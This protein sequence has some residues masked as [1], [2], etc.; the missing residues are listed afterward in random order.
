MKMI[1]ATGNNPANNQ[2]RA[3]RAFTLIELILVMALLVVVVSMVTPVFARFFNGRKA[4]S[5]VKQLVSLMQ[6]GRSRA[7]SE[8]AP[9]MLWVNAANGTYGLKEQTGYSDNDTNA[10]DFT[11]A[12]G[13]KLD[14]DRTV[15]T[16]L[17]ANSQ[18]GRILSGQITQ[19][20]NQLPAIYFMP[21]G[22][23]NSASS[24]RGISVQDGAGAPVW[25]V[26]SSNQMN[27]AVQTQ[28]EHLAA[29]RR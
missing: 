20:K 9:M 2:W 5:E 8:G 24:I 6:Y 15:T 11:V 29:S 23:I 25:I 19:S 12:D 16:Q 14:V 10:L 17:P 7:V 13:L 21:D 28:Q 22:A 1:L 26:A 27:Y 18:T 3:A 4:D